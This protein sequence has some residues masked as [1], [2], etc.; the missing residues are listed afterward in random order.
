MVSSYGGFFYD[1]ESRRYYRIPA[2]RQQ[3]WLN[4]VANLASAA[5]SRK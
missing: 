2:D 1:V 3:E 4:Y 5:D